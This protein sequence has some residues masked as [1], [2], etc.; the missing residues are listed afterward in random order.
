M[1]TVQQLIRETALKV[2]NQLYAANL[3]SQDL[4]IQVTKPEFEG[5]YTLVLFP[6]I[7]KTGKQPD[8]LANEIGAALLK[9]NPALFTAYNLIKGFLNLTIADG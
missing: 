3:G 4:Q 9:E 2:I 5:D 7:K 1:K 8:Q 6:L